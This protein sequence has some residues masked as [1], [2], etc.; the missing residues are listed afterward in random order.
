MFYS[1]LGL[2]RLNTID[3]IS[4]DS[5][6]KPTDHRSRVL[7]R[8]DGLNLSNSCVSIA[9]LF[10]IM[11]T[12]ANQS[13]FVGYPSEDYRAS[14]VDSWCPPWG[15]CALIPGKLDGVTQ[16]QHPSRQ[17]GRSRRHPSTTMAHVFIPG[18][19][20]PSSDYVRPTPTR[21]QLCSSHQASR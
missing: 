8:V 20:P 5:Q 11:H 3:T 1:G 10:L 14:F 19:T 15:S 4:Y 12:S 2:T 16:D 18:L 7:C 17:L 9:F 13:T 21:D 6:Y